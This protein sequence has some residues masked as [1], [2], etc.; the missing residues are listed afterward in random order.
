MKL[1]QLLAHR[2]MPW[3]AAAV[4]VALCLPAV[5]SGFNGDDYF[6][7][8]ILHDV[9]EFAQRSDPLLDLFVF[10]PDD[11]RRDWQFDVGFLPWW[12]DPELNIGFLRPV[13]AATHVLDHALWP[14]SAAAQHVHSLLWF[15]LAIVTVGALYRRVHGGGLVAGLAVLLFALEDSHAMPAGWLANR[16]SLLT[17][18]FAGAVVL[19]HL[20]WRR[21]HRTVDAIPPLVVL[22]VGLFCGEATLAAVAYVTAW[23]LT[24]DEG[25]WAR[26]LGALVPYGVL[27]AIWR[28]AYDLLGYGSHGSGLYLDPGQ[29]PLRFTVALVERLPLLLAGQWFQVPVDIWAVF[30]RG[31]QIGLSLVGGMLCFGVLFLLWRLLRERRVARFWALGMVL[32]LV[33]VCAAFPMARLLIHAGVGAFALLAMLAASVGLF[34]QERVDGGR[35]RRLG[36]VGMLVLHGPL[37]ALGLLA[38]VATLPV[39]GA[40]FATGAESAP[41]DEELEEQTLIFVNGNEFPAVYTSVIRRLDES[42]PVPRRIAIL[43]PMH[44]DN[45][46][47]REDAH[48]LIATIEGG[49]FANGFDRLMRN[50]DL[51]PFTAGQ[52]IEGADFDVVVRAVTD[53][54]R[55]REVAYRFHETLESPSYRWVCWRPAGFAAFD[56]PAVGQTVSLPMVHVMEAAEIHQRS[57]RSSP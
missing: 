39:F 23:Q 35:V 31:M 53:D 57:R 33:P 42:G 32:S 28:V 51:A 37:A 46:V 56:L 5:P 47:V 12:A 52:K 6:H 9:D 14:D 2:H 54:G 4:G 25:P 34:G 18:V 13:T 48:T 41:M 8:S 29:Q 30:H 43:A 44:N 7:R 3:I 10:V 19:L 17:L 40:L 20:R 15:A 49:M 38:G 16:N 36:T 1:R 11:E 22:A 55:P 27:V 45:T 26:R 21:S 24:M 50:P